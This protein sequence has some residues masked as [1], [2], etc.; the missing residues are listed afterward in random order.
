M[1]EPLS[2]TPAVRPGTPVRSWFDALLRRI[3][4]FR[5][6]PERLR[7]MRFEQAV[8]GSFAFRDQGYAMLSQSPRC[9]P[10]WL[11]DFRAACQR[12]GERPAG[13]PDRA[14]LFALPLPSGVW[15]VVG[16][17]PQGLDDRGRPGALAFHA[18]FLSR[19]DYRKAGCNPFAFAGLLRSDWDA[20]TPALLPSGVWTVEVAPTPVSLDP[21]AG[22]VATA[23][24][25]GRR[26]VI[27]SA[28]P[29]DDL[30]RQVWQTLPE[31]VRRRASV[32]TWA[33]GNGNRFDLAAVPRLAGIALDRSYLDPEDF[34]PVESVEEATRTAQTPAEIGPDGLADSPGTAP[35]SAV[36]EPGGLLRSPRA[37][38]AL[39]AAV[40]LAVAGVGLALRGLGDD[41]EPE[42]DASA[43]E[44]VAPVSDHARGE[45]SRPSTPS[46]LLASGQPD[47]E[48]FPATPDDRDP[49]E[50]RRVVEVLEDLVDRCGVSR[51]EGTTA[52]RETV[53]RGTTNP[54][55]AA[56]ME[57]LARELRYRG[58]WLSDA[59]RERIRAEVPARA[60]YQVLAWDRAVRRFAADR[61]LPEGFRNGTLRWQLAALAWSFHVEQ[62]RG[63][64]VSDGPEAPRRS[65][66]EVAQILADAL[67]RDVPLTPGPL[68]GRYPALAAY[69]DFLGR[70]PRR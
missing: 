33:F 63:L 13:V 56:L 4:G 6:V 8:Y 32:S 2:K 68:A 25:R 48:A 60:S 15:A 46:R 67:A 62:T 34:S 50:V 36:R 18:L 47:P 19:R 35:T 10:E 12:M 16:M 64:G 3:P 29:I 53:A 58:P 24:S 59:D 66:S 55:P 7:R 42:A 9:R 30:A 31:R 57:R 52:E 27:E 44:A 22:S 20:T 37:L 51:S 69:L 70:L 26:V 28:A 43:P 1:T 49:A 11:A 17:S 39:G 65:P 54:E 40:V 38:A 61:P 41:V 14:G 45:P 5:R 23:L 21:R